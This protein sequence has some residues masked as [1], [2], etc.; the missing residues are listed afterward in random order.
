[1][2]I[3]LDELVRVSRDPVLLSFQYL[4]MKRVSPGHRKNLTESALHEVRRRGH[5]FRASLCGW[6]IGLFIVT[7]SNLILKVGE[8][9]ND[10]NAQIYPKVMRNE[11]IYVISICNLQFFL[12]N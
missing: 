11:G 3:I 8:H 5:G 9:E 4:F 10:Q 2:L 6:I 1:M 12:Q 7:G